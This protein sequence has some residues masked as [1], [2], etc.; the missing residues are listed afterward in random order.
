MRT[1]NSFRS[2]FLYSRGLLFERR[3]FYQGL[4]HGGTKYLYDGNSKVVK[5]NRSYDG[6]NYPV[7][8]AIK[9]YPNGRIKQ[10][11]KYA[12]K[13]GSRSETYL[14]SEIL[15]DNYGNITKQTNFDIKGSNMGK[16]IIQYSCAG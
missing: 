16:I 6:I 8:E 13:P 10:Q 14:S 11:L 7:E 9:Y 12:L 15:F 5:T 3:D 4:K 2:Q 1:N